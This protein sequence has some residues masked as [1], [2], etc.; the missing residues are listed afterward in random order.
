[1]RNILPKKSTLK[2][3]QM[4]RKYNRYPDEESGLYDKIGFFLLIGYIV[5]ITI[6][7]IFR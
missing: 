7:N 3:N 1:M 2:T 6:I 5:L 4:K